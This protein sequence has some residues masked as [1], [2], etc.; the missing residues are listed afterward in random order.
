MALGGSTLPNTCPRVTS[1]GFTLKHS[2]LLGFIDQEA[3]VY[4]SGFFIRELFGTR[5]MKSVLWA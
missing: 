2:K 3:S 4:G 5:K 1:Q